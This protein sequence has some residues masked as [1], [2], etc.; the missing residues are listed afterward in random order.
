[1]F[2]KF[3]DKNFGTS[4]LIVIDQANDIIETYLE[5]GYD[6]TLRQLYYQFVSR[7]LIENTQKSYK[8]LGSIINDARLA[9]LVS[10]EAIEDR[11]RNVNSPSTWDSPESIIDTAARSYRED[12]WRLQDIVPEIWVE[13]E[14]LSGVVDVVGRA[15]QVST[16]ACRGYMSQSE[17]W[18]AS[19]RFREYIDRG[20]IPII[21]HIG[22]HDPSGIDMT[23]DN[24]D[25]LRLLT[26]YPIEVRRLA[27]NMDQVEQYDPPPNPAKL[28]DSRCAE[29]IKK[30]GRSSWELDALE[31]DVL[32][33]LL[34]R[35][36]EGLRDPYLWTQAVQDQEENR[37]ILKDF[38][39]GMR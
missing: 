35:E 6:L 21:L 26:E 36:V 12:K 9:G 25:R 27:L 15:E 24:A 32:V 7:D 13:K 33:E 1:M 8:R 19:V 3:I 28:T 17:M 22:D 11:T 4:S 23:R 10:W 39:E 16:L 5:Q 29:Y 31:P 38:A 14:A 30:Y 34:T 2:K 37:L 18:Q 20:Q